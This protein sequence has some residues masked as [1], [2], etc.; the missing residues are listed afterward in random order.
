MRFV[1][2]SSKNRWRRVVLGVAVTT[3]SVCIVPPTMARAQLAPSSPPQVRAA[4]TQAPSTRTGIARS[5]DGR[6]RRPDEAKGDSTG[7]GPAVGA[8]VTLHRVGRDTA[9]PVDSVL[10]SRTGRY[11]MTWR[12][13]ANDSAVYFASV[14]WGGIAY[15]SSPLRALNNTAGDAEITVFDTTSVVHPMSV[16]GRHLIV[17]RADSLNMRTIIEVFELQNDSL[18]TLVSLDAAAPTVTWSIAIPTAAKNVHA[19]QG[20]VP[21]EAFAHEPGRV[22]V[23]APIAPGL[24]QVAFTYQ[25]HADDFPLQYRAEGGAVVFEVL[26]E[27]LEGKVFGDGFQPV[28]A[29]TLENRQFARFLSQ[30]VADGSPIT[31]EVPSGMG[32]TKYYGIGIA[33]AIGFMLLLFMTRSMQRRAN[34]HVGDGVKAPSLRVPINGRTPTLPMHERLAQEI[35]ALDTIYGQQQA[36]S[37]SVTTAYRQRR[38]ELKAALADALASGPNAR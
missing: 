13:P 31:V 20:D 6:V 30:D 2:R 8:W 1:L 3:L 36:P 21:D 4:T 9:G 27:D 10:S 33:V 22:S 16:K 17:G 38:E 19:T 23:F 32:G 35:V 7:M 28:D 25:L 29:V 14:T 24:K 11:Q 26:M 12:A 34:A 18:K 5:V 15:F 37:D